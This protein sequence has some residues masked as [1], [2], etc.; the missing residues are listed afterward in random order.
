M[1]VLRLFRVLCAGPS[2]F[3]SEDALESPMHTFTCLYMLPYINV[4]TC[5]YMDIHVQALVPMPRGRGY[6][7]LYVYM[8]MCVYMCVCV[9]VNISIHI[10]IYRHSFL[11]HVDVDKA[12]AEAAAANQLIKPGTYTTRL[13]CTLRVHA[14]AD[15]RPAGEVAEAENISIYLSIYLSIYRYI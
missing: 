13:E 10:C 5:T 14:C 1:R 12:L 3:V 7:Y 8:Y 9:Y 4:C 6:M 15:G 11:C 2:L